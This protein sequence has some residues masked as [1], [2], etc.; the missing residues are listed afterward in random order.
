MSFEAEVGKKIAN[1]QSISERINISILQ[2]FWQ[3]SPLSGRGENVIPKFLR[4]KRVLKNFSDNELRI[5]SS[6]LHH[7]NFSF[8]EVIFNQGDN[9]VGFY[10][11]FSGQIDMFAKGLQIDEK[12]KSIKLED[13]NLEEGPPA[14]YVTTLEKGDIFG[15]LAFLQENAVRTA[16]A[17]AKENCQLLGIFKSDLED[18]INDHPL[19]GAKL[20]QS[21]SIVLANRLSSIASEMKMLKNKMAQLEYGRREEEK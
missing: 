3:A 16:T 8:N 4:E 6:Y 14:N 7:R 15:E 11:I 1:K 10:F 13:I 9:G 5:L 18:I 12:N 21:V 17:V 19:I 2:Y 20:L